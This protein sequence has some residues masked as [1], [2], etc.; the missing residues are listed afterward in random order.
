MM[1]FLKS[2]IFLSA[3]GGSAHAASPPELSVCI[4]PKVDP[5]AAVAAC[6]AAIGS[7]VLEENHLAAAHYTRAFHETNLKVL[8]R[9]IADCDAVVSLRPGDYQGYVCRGLA[10]AEMGKFDHAIAD[11]G[12]ALHLNPRDFGAL[13]NRARA[14]SL[15][16]D[17]VSS[18][19]DY[20]SAIRVDP[21]NFMAWNGR[22]WARIVIGKELD[23]ALS[24]CDEAIRLAP[25]DANNYNTRGLGHFRKRQ[26]AAAMHD[27]DMAL[28]RDPKVASS[29]FI[30]G[31]AKLA[32]GDATGAADVAR[33][34]SIEPGIAS[35][36]AGY[37]IRERR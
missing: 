36:F 29:Y 30:R 6:T 12:Q 17:F 2:F 7:G 20:N 26:Y 32:M 31:L 25:E 21:R 28:S 1:R 4:D 33:G 27:Y 19:P 14:Y 23:A 15:K 8:D 9:A 10:H 24:D 37:G 22:C 35:R 18:I 16:N 11:Y 5:R 13:Y 3:L 34:K